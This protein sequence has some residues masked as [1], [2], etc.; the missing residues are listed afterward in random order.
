M[1]PPPP[2]AALGDRSRDLGGTDPPDRVDEAENSRARGQGVR[3]DYAENLDVGRRV[4]AGEGFV[5]T[6]VDA[7]LVEHT[8]NRVLDIVH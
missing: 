1:L 5:P 4:G 6:G 3:Q 2:D 8:T 7:E